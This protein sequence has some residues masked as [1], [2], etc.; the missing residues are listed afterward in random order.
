V[1]RSLLTL[2]ASSAVAVAFFALTGEPPQP[3]SEP[4][5]RGARSFYEAVWFAV[6]PPQPPR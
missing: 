4:G 6:S 1:I 3:G 2:I 5:F